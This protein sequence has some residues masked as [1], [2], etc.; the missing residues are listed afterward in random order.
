MRCA[1]SAWRSAAAASLGLIGQNGAGKSTLMNV[2][3]GV[4]QAGQRRR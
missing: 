2:I 4:V 1:T 3:G